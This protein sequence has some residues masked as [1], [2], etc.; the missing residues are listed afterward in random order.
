MKIQKSKSLNAFGGMNF[1]LDLL[2]KKNVYSIFQSI[3]PRLSSNSQ[4][5]WS[6]LM[7]SLFCLYICGGEYIE[8][9]QTHLKNH[10][11]DNPYVRMPSSDTILR[12]MTELMVENQSCNTKRGKV[13]HN[14]NYNE[15]LNQLN[16]SFLKSQNVFNS[17]EVVLDYD[18]TIIFNEKSDSKMT[19][20]RNPGYQPGVC[21]LN[22]EHIL[23]IENRNGN[24]DAKS[25]QDKT[26]ARLFDLLR[27]NHIDKIHHFRADAA[28]Y[29]YDVVQLLEKE[30]ENFYIGCRNSYV[31][32][33]FTHPDKWEEI[34]DSTGE[35]MEI[36]E[37]LITPFQK[38][39]HDNQEVAKEYRLIIKRKLKSNNQLDLFTQ[40][41]YEYRAILTNNFDM[42]AVEVAQFYN[43]RG[44][45]ERQFDIMKNDFGWNYMPFST[46]EKNTVFLCLTAFCRN[47]YST[48]IQHFSIHSENIK[49]T[50][51]VK[52]F[53]FNFIILPAK[54][55]KRARQNYLRI[56]TSSKKFMLYENIL[57]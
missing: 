22:E 4:Y 50:D 53:L 35:K 39:S 11:Q 25:F 1:V 49:S 34:E 19:Y 2:Q 15:K 46:L 13:T 8:D 52:K 37:V 33:Y 6:D 31:S 30:V 41:T 10:F 9:I 24:S 44:N 27:S 38:Q 5:D 42:P 32:K 14:F 20:K 51:R 54:W 17:G 23:F 43:R 40:D 55:I 26:L 7:N 57:T 47:L 29:Q 28:S 3:F 18:N 56:Y 36:G 21:T 45:M 12:R 16:V 48:V